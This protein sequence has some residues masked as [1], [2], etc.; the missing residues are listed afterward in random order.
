[1]ELLLVLG[2]WRRAF[3]VLYFCYFGRFIGT[4]GPVGALFFDMFLT[5]ITHTIHNLLLY[6]LP[7]RTQTWQSYTWRN[8]R[9]SVQKQIFHRCRTYESNP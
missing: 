9:L 5:I 1:M 8:T 3:S 6:R 2:L 7:R 4:H